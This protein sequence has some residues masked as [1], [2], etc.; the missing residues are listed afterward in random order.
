MLNLTLATSQAPADLKEAVKRLIAFFDLFEYPLSI[1][2]I[3]YYLDKKYEILEIQEALRSSS[4][5]VIEENNGFYFLHGRQNI[6]VTRQ[7]RHNYAQRKIKIAR[8]FGAAFNKL[9]FV[10]AV[11]VANSLGG[12]NLRDGSDIDFFI[13]TAANRVWLSRL[14]CAGLAKLLNSRPTAKNKKD[15]ICLSFYLAEDS[16]D[17]SVFSLPSADPYFFYWQRSLIL[18]YNKDK[19]Y[20]RFLKINN[21]PGKHYE[22]GQTE[23][24]NHSRLSGFVIRFWNHLERAARSWQMKIMPADL[25]EQSRR[26]SGV[27]LGDGVIK[28]YLSDRRLEFFKKYEE[29]LKLLA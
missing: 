17:L 20:E 7:A 21:L 8:R 11:A 29:K 4:S 27:V 16:L 26:S 5:E 1:W 28:L 18:L 19:T 12:Y 13:I 22:I 14:F 3:Y 23:P 15:K 2:E 10:K 9:P 25:L 6:L 24:G